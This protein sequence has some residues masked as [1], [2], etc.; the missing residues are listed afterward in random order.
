MIIGGDVG[1]LPPFP[2]FQMSL[3]KKVELVQMDVMLQD[4]RVESGTMERD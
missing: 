2:P 3:H 1:S 4:V